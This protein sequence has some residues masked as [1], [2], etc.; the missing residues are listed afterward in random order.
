MGISNPQQATL[1]L[2]S[3][4]R[5]AYQA[6]SSNFASHA[7]ITAALAAIQA[8]ALVTPFTAEDPAVLRLE[9]EEFAEAVV[10]K[11][12]KHLIVQ[13]VDIEA[14]HLTRGV[15]VHSATDVSL[16]AAL[17]ANNMELLVKDP[18][19]EV[20]NITFEKMTVSSQASNADASFTA[21]FVEG[22]GINLSDISVQPS[23]AAFDGI[24]IE[25]PKNN[26][27]RLHHGKCS[28]DIIFDDNDD[29]DING[30][31][32]LTN[33][34]LSYDSTNTNMPPTV[35]TGRVRIF[36]GRIE[37]IVT[38][39]EEV[40]AESNETVFQRNIDGALD[41][42][43]TATFKMVG[44]ASFSSAITVAPTAS[45][46]VQG[47]YVDVA[48]ISGEITTVNTLPTDVVHKSLELTSINKAFEV[49]R[50]SAIERDNLVLPP[51]GS[52]VFNTDTL[53]YEVNVGTPGAPI[54]I[55]TKRVSN[56]IRIG[57]TPYATL[58]AAK[59]AAV[60]GD[61][62]YVPA[63]ITP[64]PDKNLLK[65]GVNWY[66]ENG[67]IIEYTGSDDGAIWDDSVSTG[68][69]VEITCSITGEGEFKRLGTGNAVS[70]K[71]SFYTDLAGSQI[72]ISAKRHE[73]LEACTF[74]A[75][76]GK[77]LSRVSDDLKAT[78]FGCPVAVGV[79]TLDIYADEAIVAGDGNALSLIGT[80]FLTS[81]IR[82]L[83][84]AATA[85][86]SNLVLVSGG[87]TINHF[88]DKMV[89]IKGELVRILSGTNEVNIR[90]RLLTTEDGRA[91]NVTTT[92]SKLVIHAN[93]ISNNAS[94]F[95]TLDITGGSAVEIH[96]CT[97]ENENSV[98]GKALNVSNAAADVKF[99]GC[100]MEGTSTAEVASISN[101]V[102]EFSNS[103]LNQL[104]VGAGSHGFL[105][106]GG[107]L[108][109]DHSKTILG[110]TS[111]FDVSAAAAQSV[112]VMSSY[113]NSTTKD[114]Q[115][116]ELID[117]GGMTRSSDVQ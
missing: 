114:A 77:I 23:G 25:F 68:A 30:D 6:G 9:G 69:G 80:G 7:T 107:T 85:T 66:F 67:A 92:G 27:V 113:T 84:N 18:G 14:T 1:G 82:N 61:L 13:G 22:K 71:G 2:I 103:K 31:S 11:G 62:I 106:S 4:K 20:E 63:R 39:K 40:K 96:D 64:Y 59:T 24:G 29:V 76:S 3:A 100:V 54:W 46:E 81:Y 110:N 90:A 57:N 91:I 19:E 36:G 94:G 98:T 74:W 78:D 8:D 52:S 86:S 12:I 35:Q 88:G 115:I 109:L 89:A 101:G 60:S 17:A 73:A 28:V 32:E 87:G 105:K 75:E 65:N 58:T 117:A 108:I 104:G 83:I 45:L 53:D 33:L 41:V 10:V 49:N 48:P 16:A 112:K 55:G 93:K 37:G 79:G 15:I 95:P 51:T 5:P 56:S 47:T 44:G 43:D 70:F 116:T 102:T 111:A 97:I 34:T 42:L 99:I 50:L 26:K 21:I 38:A 72:Y